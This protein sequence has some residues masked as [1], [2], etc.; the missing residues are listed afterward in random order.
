MPSSTMTKPLRIDLLSLGSSV[1]SALGHCTRG[2][3]ARESTLSFH[4]GV[5]TPLRKHR[6]GDHAH[7][8]IT[9]IGL[10][11]FTLTTTEPVGLYVEKDV[12]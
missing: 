11:Y 8:A 4:S 5:P 2:P 7:G 12:K 9:A 6:H 10:H 3:N 1:P